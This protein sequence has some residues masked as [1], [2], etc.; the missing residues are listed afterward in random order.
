MQTYKELKFQVYCNCNN[1]SNCDSNSILNSQN[2]TIWF[3]WYFQRKWKILDVYFI[4]WFMSF[5]EWGKVEW[6]FVTIAMSIK[7]LEET[8]MLRGRSR[9]DNHTFPMISKGFCTVAEWLNNTVTSVI[10]ITIKS[11][12]FNHTVHSTCNEKITYLYEKINHVLMVY[13]WRHGGHV[14]GTTQR[15]M[16]LISLS[17]PA[18]MDGW[19]CLPHL[20][21]LI[22][23]QEYEKNHLAQI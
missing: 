7:Y 20:K 12:V 14:G 18:D 15:N 5:V 9:E 3:S 1:Y 13:I 23:N 10:Y 8:R 4:H 6:N 22:A 19:H 17:D 21:R 2:L 16:L 11:L